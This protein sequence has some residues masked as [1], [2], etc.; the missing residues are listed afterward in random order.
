[1]P[2]VRRGIRTGLCGYPPPLP[3]PN[4]P[5]ARKPQGSMMSSRIISLSCSVEGRIE[6]DIVYSSFCYSAV[7]V[8]LTFFAPFSAGPD[9]RT[10]PRQSRPQCQGR[11]TTLRRRRTAVPDAVLRMHDEEL[12]TRRVGVHRTRTSRGRRGY[13]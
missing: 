7:S 8:T 2:R 4:V 6:N 11:H 3:S 9:N 1:L 5:Y 10:P 12:R 13:V